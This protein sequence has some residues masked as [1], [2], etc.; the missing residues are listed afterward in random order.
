MLTVQRSWMRFRVDFAVGALMLA[1]ASGASAAPPSAVVSGVVRDTRGVA[2]MGAMVQVLAAGPATVAT[3]FTDR[4]GRYR[5]ANLVP[6]SYQVRATAALF[7]PATRGNL[8]LRTGMRATVNLTL[9]MLSDPTAWLPAERRKPDEPGDDWT[10][11]LRSAANRP[12][13]RMLGDGEIVSISAQAIEAGKSAPVEAR[14]SAMGGDGGF[15]EGGVRNVVTL[16]RPTKGGSDLVLRGGVAAGPSLGR[17]RAAE[18]DAGYQSAAA[19]M[20]GSRLVMSFASHPELLGAGNAAGL[21]A[22]RMASARKIQLGDA[23][24]VEAGGTVYAIHTGGTALTT[25]PFLKVTVHPGEVWAVRYRLATSRDLQGF[26]GL[27]SIASDLPVAAMSGGRLSTE[28]GNHQSIGVSR[29]AG[30]GL[31]EVALY[32]DAIQRPA[33]GGTGAMS[34]PDLL[35]GAGTS[36]V[37][38]D[39]ATDSFRFLGAGYTANGM[40]VTVSEP[41]T[42]S[43]WASVEYA[44]GEALAMSGGASAQQLPG[45]SAGLHPEAAGAATAEL[46]GQVLCTGTKLRASYH[47]QPRHLVTAV[48]AYDASGDPGY[49]GFYVRQAL[50]WGDRLPQGL[51]ATVDVTNLL[52]EGYRPF[53]SADGRTLF[54]ALSPRTVQGGLSFTF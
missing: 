1:L 4:Y 24:D 32:H 29:N 5:I 27:D 12:I 50:R 7:M 52:A 15:G 40:S 49:L 31:V 35:A 10:W 25:Q 48:D 53:L 26:D 18:L 28:S 13:L 30:R 38:V 42:S 41:L 39:T 54:L 51:E 22:M 9:A 45:V 14:V 44:S 6:G 3:A 33:V 21:Q 20:G 8:Q 36:G 19:F 46:K 11:T 37:V 16:E 43:L 47:W 23:V 17:G 2:Q 34:A